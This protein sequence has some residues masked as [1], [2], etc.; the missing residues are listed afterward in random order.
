MLLLS[1]THFGPSCLLQSEPKNGKSM[2]KARL[3]SS[4]FILP[5]ILLNLCLISHRGWRDGLLLQAALSTRRKATKQVQCL[6]IRVGDQLACSQLRENNCYRKMPHAWT[7][8]RKYRE[9]D[10]NLTVPVASV[11]HI[12]GRHCFLL[13]GADTC[14][15]PDELYIVTTSCRSQRGTPVARFLQ[16]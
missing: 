7:Y 2:R 10:R 4:R 15:S 6:F 1:G 13:N 14:E 8:Q 12:V 5:S 3:C 9:A 16:L 11:I